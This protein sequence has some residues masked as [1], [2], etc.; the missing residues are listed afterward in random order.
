M[1]PQ[2]P[3][4]HT[5]LLPRRHK[6]YR[7]LV[8]L[9]A[10]I[11]LG[12]G[13]CFPRLHQLP[14]LA[15]SP[16]TQAEQDTVKAS[17][18]QCSK[19][20]QQA[21]YQQM[22]A[23]CTQALARARAM[24]DRDAEADA[25]INLA[26]AYGSL[27]QYAK[28]VEYSQHTL[29]IAHELGD[30]Q[31]ET[32][33]LINLGN[34]YKSLQQYPQAIQVLQQALSLARDLE[35]PQA[36]AYALLNLASTAW[37]MEDYPKAL[38]YSATSLQ[39][40]QAT[41]D[42]RGQGWALINLG[43]VYEALEQ[44]PQ[45]IDHFR[46]ALE[47]TQATGDQRGEALALNNLGYTLYQRHH[48][49][50][51]E[52]YLHQAIE[53]FEALP[54]AAADGDRL[55]LFE[56]LKNP[57]YNLQKVLI[58]QGKTAE[59]LTIAERGRARAFAQLLAQRVAPD[60]ETAFLERLGAAPISLA[61][62][63]QVAQNQN[64]TL[65]EYSMA[66]QDQLY[67]WVVSPDGNITFRAVELGSFAI[68]LGDR[69]NAI[70]TDI[71]QN[72]PP[73]HLSLAG[74]PEPVHRFFRT[75][76]IAA[77]QEPE[78]VD[79]SSSGLPHASPPENDLQQL[80]QI[81]IDP[82]HDLLPA[83]SD[84]HVVFIPHNALFLVPFA[85]LQKDDGA[86]LIEHHTIR[87][88][89][90]IQVLQLTGQQRQRR[91]QG[92]EN[93]LV[94]GNPTNDLPAAEREAKTI[95]RLFQTRPLLGTQATKTA[96]LQR[97]A[98]AQVIHMATHAAPNKLNDSYGGL[99]VLADP[100]EGFS[101]LTAAE[102]LQL[103]LQAELVVLSGC[104]TGISD[105]INSDGVVGLARSIMAAGVPSVLMSL[106]QVPDAPTAELMAAFYRHWQ[107]TVG[108]RQKLLTHG[109]SLLGIVA[110]VLGAAVIWR[111]LEL[112]PWPGKLGHWPYRW[113]FVTAVV[114]VT[115]MAFNP[116]ANSLPAPHLDKAQALRQ[117]MLTT[118]KTYP[119]PRDWAAFVLM[120]EGQ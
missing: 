29:K 53:V 73:P 98:Q 20:I 75:R 49:S 81:L 100:R 40:A 46:Q 62:I 108:W 25:A 94:V 47:L 7:L 60:A 67:I 105:I 110:I 43:S 50:A 70:H 66:A 90:S 8:M 68:A 51:A 28:A 58:A 63:K 14:A 4:L 56:T 72:A 22:M 76:G 102:I 97:I 86:Y 101:N 45:A 10:I 79:L 16:P 6:Y 33:A 91:R 96:V 107:P 44:Y 104:S 83:N 18:Q 116:D 74:L 27:G 32:Y 64:A 34:A 114:M 13:V 82:I 109:L 84:S 61:D 112:R 35:Y 99:I 88:A 3:L 36:E 30:K 39:L 103:Q 59:A 78:N 57:Y 1:S 2:R 54:P 87:I 85:A 113:I 106:W 92:I 69:I 65:V 41:G 38:D 118:L 21:D 37:A 120:G 119:E 11:C 19:L 26:S 52:T 71:V 9:M 95:A 55:S 77:R 111:W 117:A 17:T 93:A 5:I 48:L 80:Y 115:L 23:T 89:P 15:Q 42:Q 12:I 31:A 24:G